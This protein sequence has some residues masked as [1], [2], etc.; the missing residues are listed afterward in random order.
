MTTALA[1][2]RANP[3]VPGRYLIPALPAIGFL[4]LANAEILMF[5]HVWPIDVYFTPI[6]WTTYLL[7]ADSMVQSITGRSRM[8]D[9][10]RGFLL[11]AALSVPLWTIF[12]LY[13]LRL[14]NWTYVGVPVS[15]AGALLGYGWSFATI[16]PGILET[17]DLIESFG[18]WVPHPSPGLARVGNPAVQFSPRAH[19]GFVVFGAA[20]LIT[21]LVIPQETAAY[22]FAL[23][24]IGF[25]FLLD[26]INYRRGLPSLL[27]ELAAGRRG[28]LY[29]LLL[30]GWVCGWLWE[31]WN[32]WA[33]A[34][35]HY[36]FPMFQDWKIFE[37]PAPGF[38]GF[39]PFALECFVM[40]VSATAALGHRSAAQSKNFVRQ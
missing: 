31:F 33:A 9:S 34:K 22:L 17:A 1:L 24:W 27:G 13:N 28:R 21:P 35:W 15:W 2:S 23:V 7:I 37:M 26:P 32:N 14:A 6:A 36:I 38:L 8:T 5:R 25:V 39:L 20:C 16:T 12:E 30:S 19:L 4:L 29:S 10:P 11:C 40:Y 3:I 18:L